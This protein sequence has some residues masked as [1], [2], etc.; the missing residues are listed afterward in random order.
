MRNYLEELLIGKHSFVHVLG[1]V[2][3][4]GR[5]DLRH[6]ILGLSFMGTISIIAATDAGAVVAIP[7]ILQLLPV[8]LISQTLQLQSLLFQLHNE[9]SVPIKNLV[10]DHVSIEDHLDKVVLQQGV[11]GFLIKLHRICIPC[12][13]NEVL[14]V[15]AADLISRKEKLSFRNRAKVPPRF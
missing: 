11:V 9:F 15:V 3:A 14:R 1:F 13:V 6:A 4:V 5:G 8:H 12:V 10:W 2:A 7:L